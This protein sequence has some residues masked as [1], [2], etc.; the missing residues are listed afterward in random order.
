[1]SIFDSVEP[2]VGGSKEAGRAYHAIPGESGLVHRSDTVAR[3]DAIVSNVSLSGLTVF[4]VGCSVGGISIGLAS[5][6]AKFVWGVDYDASAV[7]VGN[8]VIEKRKLSA[9]L[10]A[11]DL[12]DDKT[13]KRVSSGHDVVVWLA[14]W[15][16]MAKQIGFDRALDR[17]AGLDCGTLIFETAQGLQDGEAGTARV[18]GANGVQRLLASAGWVSRPIY[19]SPW[20]GRTMFAC[21]RER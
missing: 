19:V 16:W 15:M 6:G 18:T 13:W 5:A 9:K 14:H 3:V 1:M 10:E 20:F 21:E 17:L 11:A 8:A 4:D 7:A 12:T 2:I